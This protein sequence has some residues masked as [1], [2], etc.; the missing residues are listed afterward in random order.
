MWKSGKKQRLGG[1]KEQRKVEGEAFRSAL[2]FNWGQL[3]DPDLKK[4]GTLAFGKG[5]GMKLA[6]IESKGQQEQ[7]DLDFA[8][9]PEQK[10]LNIFALS[11][12]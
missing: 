12:A 8:L 9:T 6:D 3:R 1:R 5:S 10:T 2:L 7:L 11:N 4:L